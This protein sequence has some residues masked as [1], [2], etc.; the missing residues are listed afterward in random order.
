MQEER[1]HIEEELH[2]LQSAEEQLQSTIKQLQ[3]AQLQVVEEA[4]SLKLQLIVEQEART[5]LQRQVG[6]VT[7]K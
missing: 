4:R 6:D 5:A 2:M 1:Q 3:L 7:I